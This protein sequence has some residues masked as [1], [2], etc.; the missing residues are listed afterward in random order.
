MPTDNI[1]KEISDGILRNQHRIVQFEKTIDRKVQEN[2]LELQ[3]DLEIQIRDA[4]FGARTATQQRR[5]KS[6]KRDVDATI[7]SSYRNNARDLQAGLTPMPPIVERMTVGAI[8]APFTFDITV[9]TLTRQEMRAL[10]RNPVVL[11]GTT[12]EN[13]WRQREGLKQRFVQE[14]RL[15]IAQGETNQQLVNR[16]LGRPT[17]ERRRIELEDGSKRSVR[18]RSGG[19]M[20]TSRRE[21]TALVRTSTQT[22]SNATLDSTYREHTDVLGAIEVLVTFDGRTTFICMSLSGGIWS[23]ESGDPLPQSP[24]QVPYPGPAPY[25]WQCRTIVSPVTKSWEELGT[26][27]RGKILDKATDPRTVRASM[28]GERSGRDTYTNFLKS[29]DAAFQDS[30]LGPRRA[31]MFRAGTL[32]LNQLTSATLVPLNLQQ[33]QAFA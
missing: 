23:I 5:L 27:T 11:G 25:H 33:L 12:T 28:T 15:G 16:V 31:A 13:W 2:L 19:I 7:N 6:L 17:G 24:K 9:P 26:R 32:Q 18:V 14:M 21:A 1:N 10:S 4:D 29:Q 22:V 30:A 3:R 8:N 20:D